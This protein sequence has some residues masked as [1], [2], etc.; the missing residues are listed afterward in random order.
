MVIPAE[1]LTFC[2]RCE[3][4]CITQDQYD[5]SNV[6]GYQP[7][8]ALSGEPFRWVQSRGRTK[9]HPHFTPNKEEMDGNYRNYR[10]KIRTNPERITG[11]IRLKTKIGD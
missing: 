7:V 3:D 11:N 1:M 4:G 5:V 9:W 10:K 8:A 2:S 6:S